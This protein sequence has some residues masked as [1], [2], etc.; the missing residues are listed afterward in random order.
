MLKIF[1]IDNHVLFREGLTSLLQSEKDLSVVGEAGSITQA[2]ERLKAVDPDIVLVNSDLPDLDE[3][4]ALQPLRAQRPRMQIVIL[5]KDE[6]QS[7]FLDAIRNGARGYIPVSYTPAGLVASIRAIARGE[8]VIP[9]P[10]VGLL[11]DEITRLSPAIQQEEIY[12][13]TPREI[14][15]LRELGKGVSNQQIAR[16]LDIAEN[17]VKVHVHNILEK[18]NMPNRRQAARFARSQGIAKPDRSY[19]LSFLGIN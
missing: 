10:M 18:L 11:L 9:R 5:S 14:E 4:R 2:A 16:N 6:R 3:F 13:L 19:R 1:L 12:Q 15:V 8:A 17:T 7:R